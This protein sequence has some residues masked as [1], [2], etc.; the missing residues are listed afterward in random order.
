M[1]KSIHPPH[2]LRTSIARRLRFC[3]AGPLLFLICAWY[4]RSSSSRAL[5]CREGRWVGGLWLEEEDVM[6]VGGKG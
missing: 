2:T 6:W 3:W 1:G 4:F 5:I